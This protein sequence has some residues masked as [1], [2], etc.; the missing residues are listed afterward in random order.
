MKANGN[1]E[2]MT[3]DPAVIVMTAVDRGTG[4]FT[5]MSIP[6]KKL[7][8]DYVVKSLNAFVSQLG[9]VQVTIQYVKSSETS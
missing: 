5:A 7:E 1:F 2:E 3:E 6:T 8:K 4:F 9:H